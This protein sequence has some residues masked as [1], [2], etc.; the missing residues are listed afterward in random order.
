MIRKSYRSLREFYGA[1]TKGMTTS[2]LQ[3]LWGPELKDMYSFY[4]KSVRAANP[5][6]GKIL[7]ILKFG[8]YLFQECRS[9]YG[10]CDWHCA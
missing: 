1:F 3:R 4:A 2:E 9:I 5:K 6:D 7:R 10:I 8:W